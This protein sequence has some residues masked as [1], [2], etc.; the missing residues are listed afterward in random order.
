M[1]SSCARLSLLIAVGIA[2]IAISP[3]RANAAEST[4][5]RAAILGQKTPD[6]QLNDTAGKAYVLPEAKDARLIVVA[7]LGVECPLAKLYG[8]RLEHLATEYAER[9]VRVVGIDSNV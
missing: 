8:P 4:A 2:A 1:T 6:I 7:F 9:G 3:A 5:S